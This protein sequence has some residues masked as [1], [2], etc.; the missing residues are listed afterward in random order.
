MTAV[1]QDYSILEQLSP[2]DP[3]LRAAFKALLDRI[4]ELERVK[5]QPPQP[6]TAAQLAQVRSALQAGGSHALRVDGLRGRLA[7]AQP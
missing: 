2:T 4:A 1:P 7:D 6:L 5:A 3:R